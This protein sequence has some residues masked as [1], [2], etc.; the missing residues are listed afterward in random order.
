VG[1]LALLAVVVRVGGGVPRG[2]GW[3]PVVGQ[4]R[5]GAQR[6]LWYKIA[7][8]A[9]PTGMSASYAAHGESR[10]LDTITKRGRGALIHL[11]L[12]DE[13]HAAVLSGS[14]RTDK[15]DG[16][17]TWTWVTGEPFTYTNWKSLEPSGDGWNISASRER[18]RG[19]TARGQLGTTSPSGKITSNTTRA[20]NDGP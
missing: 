19:D 20:P 11:H 15:E 10:T 7:R 1:R 6:A 17:R 9:G 5:S 2:G 8:P 3:T 4:G 18:R 16:T 14:G 12:P 13:Q